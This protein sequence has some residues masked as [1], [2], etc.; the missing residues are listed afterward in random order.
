MVN[1]ESVHICL[2]E[3]KSKKLNRLLDNGCSFYSPPLSFQ[4]LSE[5]FMNKIFDAIG[6]I[7]KNVDEYKSLRELTI[8]LVHVLGYKF[9]INGIKFEPVKDDMYF[10]EYNTET[11]QIILQFPSGVEVKDFNMKRI[12]A[13]ILH[14]LTHHMQHT[15]KD[16]PH[17]KEYIKHVDEISPW[18]VEHFLQI[19]E[20]LPKILSTSIEAA[21]K[22]VELTSIDNAIKHIRGFIKGDIEKEYDGYLIERI[23]NEYNFTL[24]G[25]NIGFMIY[26]IALNND[27]GLRKRFLQSFRKAK[28]YVKALEK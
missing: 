4:G 12:F 16:F 14:E 26:L 17:P 1:I 9:N 23:L 8:D 27:K 21:G 5:S 3:S 11:S 7:I 19:Y 18:S 20:K 28:G 15:D 25:S 6:E 22:G 13:N 10:A 24:I 2:Q